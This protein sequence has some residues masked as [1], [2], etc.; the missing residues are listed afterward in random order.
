MTGLKLLILLPRFLNEPLY[1]GSGYL[2]F[3]VRNPRFGDKKYF[4]KSHFTLTPEHEKLSFLPLQTVHQHGWCGPTQGSSSNVRRH[5]PSSSPGGRKK[6][7]MLLS[8]HSK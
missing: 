3:L 5:F 7:G 4:A 8:T 2:C 1:P 6:A